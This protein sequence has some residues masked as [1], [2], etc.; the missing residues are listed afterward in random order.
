VAFSP[1]EIDAN[2]GIDRYYS[3]R[4]N[5]L[6]SLQLRGIM[7]SSD[8]AGD[9]S[10]HHRRDLLFRSFLLLAIIDKTGEIVSQNPGGVEV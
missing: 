1:G 5:W 6:D 9:R 10:R 3:P 8:S 4:R 2:R 7:G